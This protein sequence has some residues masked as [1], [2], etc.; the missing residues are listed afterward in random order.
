MHEPVITL[1]YWRSCLFS[2]HAM[3]TTPTRP[4]CYL[5]YNSSTPLYWSWLELPLSVVFYHQVAIDTMQG[6][7]GTGSAAG[8]CSRRL[9]TSQRRGNAGLAT[10]LLQLSQQ[11][12]TYLKVGNARILLQFQ[13]KQM[14][15]ILITSNLS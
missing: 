2:T 9:I 4:C 6:G 11:Q 13:N 15:P 7:G 8:S 5:P 12:H 14:L 3:L 1:A 10:K